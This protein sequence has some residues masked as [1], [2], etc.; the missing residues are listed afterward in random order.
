MGPRSVVQDLGS[1]RRIA[2]GVDERDRGRAVDQ[3]EQLLDSGLLGSEPRQRVLDD[4][5]ASTRLQQL[6]AQLVDLRHRQPAVVGD[7]QVLRALQP[8]RQLAD[9]PFLVLSQHVIS[10]RK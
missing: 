10:S 2:L 3:L 7:E 9:D 6:G 5:E 1:R 8:F 4:R